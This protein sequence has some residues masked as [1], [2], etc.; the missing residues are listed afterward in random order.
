MRAWVRGFVAAVAMLAGAT[1]QA[2]GQVNVLCSVPVPWC[3]AIAAQFER[4]TGIKVAM[5][6]RAAGEAMAQI[7][8]EKAN[9]KYDV[10]YAGSGDPHLQAA[11]QGLTDEYKSP[12]LPQLYDW[13]V[14]QAEQAK[15]RTVGLFVGALGFGYNS[16]L[17]AK[18]K[19]PAPKCWADLAKPEY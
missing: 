19:L 10:W 3:E 1:T 15:Y 6:Q 13:A 9:P 14:K 17:L 18:K 16:E 8:A 2:Q 5:S 4:D 7:A 11:E 12:L